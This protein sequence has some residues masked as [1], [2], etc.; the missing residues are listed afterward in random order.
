LHTTSWIVKLGVVFLLVLGGV[1][2]AQEPV[3][4]TISG[5]LKDYDGKPVKDGFVMLQGSPRLCATTD[6]LGQFK[7]MGKA[8]ALPDTL[9][10]SWAGCDTSETPITKAETKELIIQLKAEDREFTKIEV[11]CAILASRAGAN[12]KIHGLYEKLKDGLRK[13]TVDEQICVDAYRGFLKD[14]GEAII[15]KIL[16]GKELTAEEAKFRYVLHAEISVRGGYEAFAKAK[17]DDDEFRVYTRKILELG[18]KAMT[19]GYTGERIL[20]E[21]LEAMRLY[22]AVQAIYAP[23]SGKLMPGWIRYDK[24]WARYPHVGEE[25]LDFTF[26]DFDA[27]LKSAAYSNYSTLSLTEFLRFES[28]GNLF[29]RF[30]AHS[31]E[32]S[33]RIAPA[34]PATL[35]AR[36]HHDYEKLVPMAEAL[37]KEKLTLLSWV[38]WEDRTYPSPNCWL[39][40]YL[41]RAYGDK[42]NVVILGAPSPLYG[43]MVIDEFRFF[44]PNPNAAPL[45]G[46]DTRFGEEDNTAERLARITKVAIMENPVISGRVLLELPGKPYNFYGFSGQQYDHITLV[47]REGRT[48]SMGERS[49][50]GLTLTGGWWEKSSFFGDYYHAFR[51]HTRIERFIRAFIANGGKFDKGLL[52]TELHQTYPSRQFAKQDVFVVRSIDVG[53]GILHAGWVKPKGRGSYGGIG[54]WPGEPEQGIVV[55]FKI[56]RDTRIVLRTR[57]G[58]AWWPPKVGEFHAAPDDVIKQLATLTD[59]RPGDRFWADIV[60]AEKQS[61]PRKHLSDK[62][63]KEDRLRGFDM[64]KYLDKELDAVRIQN[65]LDSRARGG[66]AHYI[67]GSMMPLYGTI[68]EIDGVIATVTIAKEDVVNMRGYQFWKQEEE[69]ADTAISE[70][71]YARRSLPV[72]KRW[73]EG[74]DADRTYKFVADRAVRMTRNGQVERA[75]ADLKVGDYVYVTYHMWYETQHQGK[76]LI[77]PETIMAASAVTAGTE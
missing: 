38:C 39:V 21:D 29:S 23:A 30:A 9:L 58:K 26:L 49:F 75:A 48:V 35:R 43:D 74:S 6:G 24:K 22:R 1:A 17:D 33:G 20:A 77:Y 5:T 45:R 10:A 8:L 53:K 70:S 13:I 36:Y 63:K 19:K 44:G 67:M 42:L 69:I 11:G 66:N 46:L 56:S 27:M 54:D 3:N 72:I 50:N 71:G 61:T 15:T 12:R 32:E 64:A 62:F 16:P 14:K 37:S 18:K 31:V 68:A 47:D 59:L 57:D 76:C 25:M 51:Q 7:I 65:F 60:I 2:S 4:V 73:A 40:E 52:D 34:Q 55:R 41:R 28:L